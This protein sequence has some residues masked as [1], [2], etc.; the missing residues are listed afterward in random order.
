MGA[1][2]WYDFFE[3]KRGE[4]EKDGLVSFGDIG[5]RAGGSL[6]DNTTERFD[7]RE[8]QRNG[9]VTVGRIV[10]DIHS[11]DMV[12]KEEIIFHVRDV[13]YVTPSGLVFFEEACEKECDV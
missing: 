3:E 2:A 5:L 10:H 1:A 6:L 4:I 13:V 11:Q 12:V 9:L 8:M 7:M